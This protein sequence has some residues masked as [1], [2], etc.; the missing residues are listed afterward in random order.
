VCEK[1]N[2]IIWCIR[3]EEYIVAIANA[4]LALLNKDQ[5]CSDCKI[6]IPHSNDKICINCSIDK[7]LT[8]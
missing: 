5:K 7:L 1:Q 3:T 4:K 8:E 6:P 2:G